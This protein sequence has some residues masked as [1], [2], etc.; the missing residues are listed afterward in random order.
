MP[1]NVKCCEESVPGHE[2][3]G[4][5]LNISDLHLPHL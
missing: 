3:R 4:K 5:L 2:D 1:G